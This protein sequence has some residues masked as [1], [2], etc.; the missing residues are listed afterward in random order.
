MLIRLIE[1]RDLNL[2]EAARLM[3]MAHASGGDAM[4]ACF[5]A[6][7]HYA[8]WRPV[9]AV[10][11]ADTD[12]NA[13]TAPIADWR[14]QNPTPNH[15][16]YTAA[17]NCH[18]AAVA[19]AIG[20]FFGTDEVAITVDSEVTGEVRRFDRLSDAVADVIDARVLAGAHFRFSGEAG[21][22]LGVSVARFVT[23]TEFTLKGPKGRPGT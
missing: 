10:R 21:T 3:A 13:A 19:T 20:A 17:H 16:E 9:H 12:G 18:S 1:E 7:Y 22:A 4:I 2:F 8:S 23:R 14:P 11:R 5:E 15:P 6:K